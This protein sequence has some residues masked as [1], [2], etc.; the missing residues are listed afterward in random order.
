MG[1]ASGQGLGTFSGSFFGTPFSPKS[2]FFA[3]QNQDFEVHF[4]VPKRRDAGDPFFKIFV[5][6]GFVFRDPVCSE[7]LIFC[8]EKSRFWASFWALKRTPS[9]AFFFH[10]FAFFKNALMVIGISV[11]LIVLRLFSKPQFY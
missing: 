9:E 2:V 6:F 7:N 10:F 3:I 5:I 4:G 1:A 8:K 11:E